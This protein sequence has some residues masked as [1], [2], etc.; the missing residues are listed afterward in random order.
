MLHESVQP[1]TFASVPPNTTFV[2]EGVGS[3]TVTGAIGKGARIEHSGVGNLYLNGTFPTEPRSWTLIA[4]GVGSVFFR[5]PPGDSV[6]LTHNGV[7][8]IVGQ[9]KSAEVHKRK[10]APTA[11]SSSS[12]QRRRHAPLLN[13]FAGISTLI[14]GNSV[15]PGA[16]I[17]LGRVTINGCVVSDSLAIVNGKTYI[18]GKEVKQSQE[19][20]DEF[21][22]VLLDFERSMK[23]RDIPLATLL[24]SVHDEKDET[25]VTLRKK[26]A[27]CITEE[28]CNI[29]VRL[30]SNVFDLD[31]IR[32]LPKQEDP[33]RKKSFRKLEVQAAFDIV[34]ELERFVASKTVRSQAPATK[35]API[36]ID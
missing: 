23:R 15:A 34:E 22:E 3:A 31:T 24:G 7:G 30:N 28:W 6:I 13:P 14:A 33:L 9:Y 17:S 18:G 8:N 27:D 26:Y 29:P 35:S 12:G 25:Y 16:S 10:N 1:A 19:P 11:T 2:V 36:Q 5:T 20:V 21:S 4:T 32:K